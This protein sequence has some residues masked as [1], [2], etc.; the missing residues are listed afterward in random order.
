MNNNQN[1]K[2]NKQ[3]K[4]NNILNNQNTSVN[5]KFFYPRILLRN[6]SDIKY[7]IS[8]YDIQEETNNNISEE[9]KDNQSSAKTLTKDELKKLSSLEQTAYS[10]ALLIVTNGIPTRGDDLFSFFNN[11]KRDRKYNSVNDLFVSKYGD[12]WYLIK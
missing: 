7:T 10:K 3:N 8:E 1:N 9:T 6:G 11:Q 2:Q 5:N 4:Q 12:R